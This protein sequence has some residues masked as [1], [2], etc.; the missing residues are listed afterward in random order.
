M[1]QIF[2][3][4]AFPQPLVLL[5]RG[6]N[7]EVVT[8]VGFRLGRHNPSLVLPSEGGDGFLHCTVQTSWDRKDN[9]EQELLGWGA[10]S[11]LTAVLFP[12]PRVGIHLLPCVREIVPPIGCAKPT[13]F[14]CNL[15]QTL[16]YL[17]TWCCRSVNRHNCYRQNY[18][19]ILGQISLSISRQPL[20]RIWGKC[21]AK[22]CSYHWWF[23]CFSVGARNSARKEMQ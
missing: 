2:H 17:K 13:P 7:W 18:T 9:S 22:V 5:E 8:K 12:V 20:W 6:G 4:T 14:N 23:C 10:V 11:L 16:K 3:K 21:C 1:L 19:Q 15:I